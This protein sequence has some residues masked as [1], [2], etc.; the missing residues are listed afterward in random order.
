MNGLGRVEPV[1]PPTLIA[2]TAHSAAWSGVSGLV[3]QRAGK[4]IQFAETRFPWAIAFVSQR[5]REPKGAR[6]V[7]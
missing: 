2:R 4:G 1:G 3:E 5:F 6:P 7:W